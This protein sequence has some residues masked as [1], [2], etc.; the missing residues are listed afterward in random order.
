MGDVFRKWFSVYNKF[1]KFILFYPKHWNR[2]AYSLQKEWWILLNT[3][4]PSDFPFMFMPFLICTPTRETLELKFWHILSSRWWCLC[5]GSHWVPCG[6][7]F[8]FFFW[9]EIGAVRSNFTWKLH[10]RQHLEEE[11]TELKTTTKNKYTRRLVFLYDDFF[12]TAMQ[13]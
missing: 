7:I 13:K 6:F 8:P 11:K 9:L 1:G 4:L 10:L 12:K 3:E 2:T 5:C